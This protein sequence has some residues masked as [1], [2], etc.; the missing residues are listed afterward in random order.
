M[1]VLRHLA[2]PKRVSD[3]GPGAGPS[4]AVDE[5]SEQF[6]CAGAGEDK[7]LPMGEHLERAE[8]AHRKLRRGRALVREE[9]VELLPDA[10]DLDGLHDEA[11]DMHA[12]GI[13]GITG[14]SRHEH[15]LRIGSSVFQLG[16]EGDAVD[17]RQLDV[18]EHNVGRARLLYGCERG[19]GALEVEHLRIGRGGDDGVME[20]LEH[21]LL[22]VDGEYL[23][24]PPP[25][26]SR[27]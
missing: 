22:I 13:Q 2:F 15:D 16:G 27:S 25:W 10:L 4:L 24:L 23:H 5:E 17:A 6:L 14:K 21:G 19:F 8:A 26:E 11:V 20:G 9:H 12:V 7:R 1:R 18:R 3:L